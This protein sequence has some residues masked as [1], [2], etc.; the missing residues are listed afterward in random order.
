MPG[1]TAVKNPAVGG[2][3]GNN[4]WSPASDF[5]QKTSVLLLAKSEMHQAQT[6]SVV[7][8]LN[9]FVSECILSLHLLVCLKFLGTY[10]LFCLIQKS[11]R[12]AG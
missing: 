9:I 5:F 2:N 3:H 1:L 4:V 12:W 11:Q 6:V 8:C 7:L 10:L